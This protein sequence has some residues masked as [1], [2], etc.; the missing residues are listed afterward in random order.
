MEADNYSAQTPSQDWQ[1]N[2]FTWASIIFLFCGAKLF[3][4]TCLLH[5]IL[6]DEGDD[7]NDQYRFILVISVAK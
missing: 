7:Q 6:D 4:K 3:L 2:N 1:K 5:L